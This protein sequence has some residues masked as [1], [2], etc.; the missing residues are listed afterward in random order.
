MSKTEQHLGTIAAQAMLVTHHYTHEGTPMF[1]D[2]TRALLCAMC[3]RP[4]IAATIEADLCGAQRRV[5]FLC[6][7]CDRYR[8]YTLPDHAYGGRVGL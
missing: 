2:D 7:A 5:T 1:D 4:M 8:C 3:R 6:Q